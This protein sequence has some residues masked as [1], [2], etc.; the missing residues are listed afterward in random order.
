MPV[1][2]ANVFSLSESSKKLIFPAEDDIRKRIPLWIKFY[3]YEYTNT[4][5]GRASAQNVAAGGGDLG[6]MGLRSVEKASIFLPAP[7]NFQTN[8]SH[9]YAPEATN[10]PNL[11]QNY[12]G[13]FI[14]EI[15]D[16]LGLP[17]AEVASGMEATISFFEGVFGNATGFESGIHIDTNDAMYV[18]SGPCRSFEIRMNLP[19]LTEKDS[20]AAAAIIRAFEALSL[21]TANSVPLGLNFTKAYHPPLWVFG[22]GPIDQRKY[23][24]DWTGSPQIC[25]LRTVIHKKTAFETNALAALGHNTLLKPVA[26]T[27]TL[28]FLELEPAYRAQNFFGETSTTILNRSSVMLTTGV[29]GVLKPGP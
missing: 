15:V 18:N 8:T 24:Q 7:V 26:Y 22:V 28:N 1:Q 2:G 27:L 3:C 17:V 20:Q 29:S 10:A 4:A 6:I 5:F 19:C 11:F 13:D 14:S 21:P 16:L 23:D 9:K 25:V 12:L